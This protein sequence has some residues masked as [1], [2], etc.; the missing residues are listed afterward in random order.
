MNLR[1]NRRRALLGT[2]TALALAAGITTASVA[3][4]DPG[5]A[6]VPLTYN[7]ASS[8]SAQLNPINTEGLEQAMSGLP[9]QDNTAA[10][11]NIGG[12]E[13][14]EG[15]AGVRDLDSG[16][17]AELGNKI[18]IGSV[19]KVFNTAIVLQLA[20]EGTVDLD[21]SVRE[22]LPD[23]FPA[24]YPDVTV[25]QLL[26][27]TSGLPAP[28]IKD[29]DDFDWQYAHRFDHWEP[30]EYL[31][32]GFENPMLFTPGTAQDYSNVNTMVSGLIIEAVTG[33]SWEKNLK[34]R[35]VKPLGLHDTYAPGDGT[36]I[37]GAHQRGYQAVTGE[38]GETEFVDVTVWNQS[39]TW[40]SG[41]VVSTVGDLRSFMAALFGGEVVAQDELENMFTV[42]QVP[43]YDGDDDA[44][45]DTAAVKSMGLQRY[46][47]PGGIEVWG[48]SGSRL[49]YSTG[50]GATK[51]GSRIVTYNATS[52][53]AKGTGQ[54]ANPVTDGI[55]FAGFGF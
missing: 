34:R 14:W 52:T 15:A 18:R 8:Q 20:G 53:D 21:A 44:C 48:K 38:A 16:K 30:E 13:A 31:A 17:P 7:T 4:A 51:D 55:I 6:C 23:L 29:F 33:D 39:S 27:H 40:A 36:H 41:D 5:P 24:D 45:N 28:Q 11:V 43:I 19:T 32:L 50:V 22:Y 25:G 1:R 46:E 35:I 2:A 9:S 37:K 47:L 26:N 3:A 42:P 54:D 12:T 49:G 10:L